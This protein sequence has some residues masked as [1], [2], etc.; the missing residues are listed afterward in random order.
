MRVI[1]VSWRDLANP[2]A[3]GAEVLVDRLLGDLSNKGNDVALVCAKPVG[4]RAYPVIAAGGTYSQ[5]VRAPIVCATRL[6]SADV[7]IDVENGLPFFSPLWWRKPSVC[8]VHHV[9]TEQWADYF[10]TAVAS[11]GRFVESRVMP[12]IYR[13]RVFVA[14]SRSTAVALGDIGVPE[15]RIEVIESGVDLPAGVPTPKSSEP[16]FLSLSRIV[17]H[18][19]IDLMLSAWERVVDEIPGR[20]VIAGDGPGL[21]ALRQRAAKIPRVDVAG[22]VSEKEKTRLLRESWF[23]ISTAHHEGWGMSVMEAAAHGTPALAVDVPGIRDSIADG[24]TG[25]L[26]RAPESELPD[27]LARAWVGLV[28]D[29]ERLGRLSSATRP[30]AARFTWART[31]E[32]WLHVLERVASSARDT[33]RRRASH[34]L[35]T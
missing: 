33:G 32:R 10:P 35:P 13:N 14:V 2:L 4:D 29:R 5:Y 22:R 27:A 20:L 15:D 3:G 30:W 31:T 34:A 11:A 1:V 16:L 6:R 12:K 24:V 8:L 17:P 7:L 25:V 23:L 26:V 19:R 28:R 18:K 9:H 21:Q